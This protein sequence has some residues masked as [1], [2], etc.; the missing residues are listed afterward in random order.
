M[1]L[2]KKLIAPLLFPIPIILG[3]LLIGLVQMW[4]SRGAGRP[5]GRA[6]VVGAVALMVVFS[7]RPL[8]TMIMLD[9]ERQYPPV[10]TPADSSIA[11]IVVLAA[12]ATDDP[13]LATPHRLSQSSLV[14]L[15]EGI[16][17]LRQL[18]SAKLVLSGGAPFSS[19]T[20]ASIMHS[21]ALELGVP[22]SVIV[23]EDQSLDTKDQA[24]AIADILHD[25]PFLL[26]TSAMHVPRSMGLFEY[27]GLAPIAA[28]T[29][30]LARQPTTFHPGALYPSSL[31]I[32][33]ARLVW[34]EYLGLMWAKLRGQA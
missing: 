27:Q 16:R 30:H 8:P 4:R 15:V 12:G 9:I 1:F 22:D 3:L 6:W 5:K 31:N 10:V 13:A 34:R 24:L 32:R 20:A 14:R 11:W 2:L 23:T 7:F 33:T 21:L 19:V 26:V 17:L 29:D 18:P 28:P 25:D